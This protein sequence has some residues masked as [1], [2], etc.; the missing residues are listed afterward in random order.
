LPR[1]PGMTIAICTRNRPEP[2]RRGIADIAGQ[3]PDFPCEI[4]IVDDGNLSREFRQGLESMLAHRG[5]ITFAYYR[6]TR[7]G[8]LYS[9]MLA[10]EQARHEVILFLD[11][12]ARPM[13]GYFDRLARWYER[14]QVAGVGGIDRNIRSNWRW[15]LFARF[16][17]YDSR[18][19]GKLSP[20]GY[21]GSMTRWAA[22]TEPFRTEYLLGCNMS[23]RR[24]ALADLAP[25]EWLQ[26]YSMG[27][28]LY[29]SDQALRSGELWIDPSL[30]VDHL[31]SPASRD[32]EAK[33]AYTEIVNHHYLLKL[34]QAG[35]IRHAAHLW[36]SLGLLG[37]AWARRKWRHKAAPYRKAIRF[38]LADDW[39]RLTRESVSDPGNG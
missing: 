14:P 7:P 10:V 39:R 15:D 34:K 2:L 26:G 6:K 20:S 33:V 35:M 38:V 31:L 32:G 12:D 17:L 5:G 1:L 11:D 23:F 30:Q 28:D 24:S 27:E 29:L 19:P 37:R 36:T 21:G 16:I 25:A 9:R 8:L 3:A 13:P 22:M 18:N 4:M